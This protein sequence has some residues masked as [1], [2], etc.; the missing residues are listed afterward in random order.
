MFISIPSSSL[1]MDIPGWHMTVLHSVIWGP[2]SLYL[3]ALPFS[4]PPTFLH[5][6]DQGRGDPELTHISS[7]H[8]QLPRTSHV[9]LTICKGHGRGQGVVFCW[10]SAEP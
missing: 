4:K 9:A 7:A 1:Y 5:L 10:A 2:S 8:V 3:V 6:P